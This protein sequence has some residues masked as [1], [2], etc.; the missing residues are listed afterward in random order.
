MFISAL[1]ACVHCSLFAWWVR[2]LKQH[3][4]MSQ[5]SP[6]LSLVYPWHSPAPC[7]RPGK[8]HF[9][10]C[11][12]CCPKGPGGVLCEVKEGICSPMPVV[13]RAFPSPPGLCLRSCCVC[14]R[15]PSPGAM[16]RGCKQASHVRRGKP[17]APADSSCGKGQ[18]GWLPV[19]PL[20]TWTLSWAGGEEEEL[21]GIPVF[22]LPWDPFLP[23]PLPCTQP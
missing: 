10:S 23:I 11:A 22:H 8:L 5:G 13:Q 15:F 3:S 14:F 19:C 12:L 2:H 1:Q 6:D 21:C 9:S 18:C 7:A 20:G 4:H 17:T 16:L